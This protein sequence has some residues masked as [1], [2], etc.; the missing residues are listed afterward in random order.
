[1][2][3]GA[4]GG[5][6]ADAVLHHRLDVQTSRHPLHRTSI[7][8]T[9]KALKPNAGAGF[10]GFVISTI[11]SSQTMRDD[12]AKFIECLRARRFFGAAGRRNGY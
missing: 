2:V 6:H 9:A 11:A 3:A 5:V 8:K 10:R 7:R 4:V 1:V 12:F